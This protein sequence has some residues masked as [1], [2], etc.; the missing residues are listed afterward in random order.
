MISCHLATFRAS[1][2]RFSAI[3]F[4]DCLHY[5]EIFLARFLITTVLNIIS[6]L[7]IVFFLCA[8]VVWCDVGSEFTNLIK[9]D[10]DVN[11]ML[12]LNI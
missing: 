9:V 7:H 8:R 6:S 1:H 3:I 2:N 10:V 12:L 11:E 5:C 4:H